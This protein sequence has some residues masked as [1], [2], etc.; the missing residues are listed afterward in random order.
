M[1]MDLQ[2]IL[3]QLHEE[4]RLVSDVISV[5]ERLTAN[6]RSHGNLARAAKFVSDEAKKLEQ[7][8]PRKRGRPRKN[9]T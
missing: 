7:A 6:L 2:H 1:P 8:P 5:L 3:S 4:R 9:P